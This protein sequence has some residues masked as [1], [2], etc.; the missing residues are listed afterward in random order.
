MAIYEVLISYAQITVLTRDAQITVS[1][2]KCFALLNLCNYSKTYLLS[3]VCIQK[4]A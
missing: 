4:E 1:F 3:N 2:N